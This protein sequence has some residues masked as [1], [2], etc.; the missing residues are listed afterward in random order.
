MLEVEKHYNASHGN[1]ED[2]PKNGEEDSEDSEKR[3]GW[4]SDDA[5]YGI[6]GS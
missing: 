1:I 4:D 6:M 3:T 5:F 2:F